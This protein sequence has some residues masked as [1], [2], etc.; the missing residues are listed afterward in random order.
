MVEYGKKGQ[1]LLSKI[2]NFGRCLRW[3]TGNLQTFEARVD[4][5]T[6]AFLMCCPWPAGSG[7]RELVKNAKFPDPTPD[8]LNQKPCELAQ[9]SVH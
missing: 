9:Q 4:C 8:R 5:S 6:A 1:P 2:V 3:R 7:H